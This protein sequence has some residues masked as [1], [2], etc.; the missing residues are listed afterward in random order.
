MAELSRSSKYRSQ[1]NAPLGDE[2]RN[3]LVERLNKAYS[4][5]VVAPDDYP[6]LLDVVF[7]ATTL[8]QVAE[9][10]EALPG[11]ATHDVPAIV[12]SGQGRP[13]ELEPGRRPSAS[14]VAKVAAGG[15]VALVVLLVVLLVLIL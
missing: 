13:G 10:V 9:V 1:P 3:D 7:G 6:R 8:G 4:D 15:A 2:E 14:V 12:E 11:V 5:G